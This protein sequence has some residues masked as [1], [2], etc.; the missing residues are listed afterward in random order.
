MMLRFFSLLSAFS[1]LTFFSFVSFATA[2]GALK[3]TRTGAA[4]SG[5][6]GSC[7][8]IGRGCGLR[9]SLLLLDSLRRLLRELL[10]LLLPEDL[11][12]RRLL[13]ERER[14]RSST[15]TQPL[16][17]L[18][19][20]PLLFM[21]AP[22]PLL[23]CTSRVPALASGVSI[24]T[25]PSGFGLGFDAWFPPSWRRLST[26]ASKEKNGPD[27]A[28]LVGC[29]TRAACSLFRKVST[30]ASK[31]K[32]APPGRAAAAA[33]CPPPAAA[34]G[35]AMD[36][37]ASWPPAPTNPGGIGCNGLGCAIAGTAVIG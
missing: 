11:R 25:S 13:R 20:L 22:S 14:P 18:A 6:I 36:A 9:L 2:S 21:G 35:S 4:D 3:A 23:D 7:F 29:P 30:G 16:T 8:G 24:C 19:V 15:V 10:D 28:A 31:E 5:A 34:A 1:T 12:R 17:P 37:C 27:A 26:G 32:N 33:C